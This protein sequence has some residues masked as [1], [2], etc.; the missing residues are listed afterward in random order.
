M[1]QNMVVDLQQ[2]RTNCN[3]NQQ[4]SPTKVIEWFTTLHEE[5]NFR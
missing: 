4:V 1:V 2:T 5:C 3:Y